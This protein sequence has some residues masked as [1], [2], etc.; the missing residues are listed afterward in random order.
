MLLCHRGCGL[1]G[2]YLNYKKLPCCAK[3]A[4][5]CPS[6]KKKIGDAS[7]KTRRE[8]PVKRTDEQKLQQSKVLKK[9]WSDGKRGK[10][11]TIEKIRASNKKFFA[12]NKRTPWNKN[13]VGVQTAWNKGRRGDRL[14]SRR[15]V[16]EEDYLDYQ[17]YKRAV[18]KASRRTYNLNEATINP[19]KLNLGRAGTELAHQIDHKIPVSLGYARKIPVTVMADIENLQLLPWKDNLRKSNNVIM[20][21]L[22]LTKLLNKY[23]INLDN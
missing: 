9:Q 1:E 15:K 18:Y 19:N 11:E 5:S 3:S 20:D 2:V 17:R 10:E 21:E 16:S 4:S 8:H 14:P 12:E 13:K 22:L 6:I 23:K 7:G